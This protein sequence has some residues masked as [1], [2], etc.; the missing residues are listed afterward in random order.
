MK[1]IAA[2]EVGFSSER[3][4]NINPVMQAYVDQK[5]LPGLI[6][7]VARRGKI[8]HFER[9]G[10]MDIE[11]NKPMQSDTIFRIYS[12]TKPIT[13]IALMMLYEEGK[14]R[15]G[16]PVAKFIPEFKDLKVAAGV[17][18]D[19]PK[20]EDAHH[21]MTIRELMS[22]T[23]LGNRSSGSVAKYVSKYSIRL[24]TCESDGGLPS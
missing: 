23:V 16:D 14:F 4:E 9:F 19:G 1:T 17:G 12:M 10:L 20:V 13:S 22:H 3:L 2:E 18:A 21:A 15:L 5:K 6:S 8:V 24:L 11:A 7:L